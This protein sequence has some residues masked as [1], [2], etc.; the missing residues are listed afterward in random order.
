M[1]WIVFFGCRNNPI[2]QCEQ[3]EDI[4]NCLQ[5]AVNGAS[6]VEDALSL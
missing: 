6:S 1:F 4:Q 2:A 5:T 3:A